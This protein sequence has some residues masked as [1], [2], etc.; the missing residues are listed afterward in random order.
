MVAN[1]YLS[2]NRA[3]F[4]L[5]PPHANYLCKV[6]KPRGRRD[7]G[8]P[9]KRW[10]ADVGTGDS[11]YPEVMMTYLKFSVSWLRNQNDFFHIWKAL[12]SDSL[13]IFKHLKLL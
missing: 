12:K 6:Y 7:V 3:F 5:Y 9:R 1:F 10:T 2:H 4:L 13:L 11:P 8:R